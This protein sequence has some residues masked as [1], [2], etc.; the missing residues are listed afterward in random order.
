[1]K[2]KKYVPWIAGCL[3]LIGLILVLT[4][5][6]LL[7]KNVEKEEEQ[8]V[9]LTMMLPQTH[10]KNFFIQLIDQFE[11]EHE[12]IQIELQV[13]PDNQWLDVVK[14]KVLVC[15]TPDII[16]IDRYLLEDIGAE[17]FVEMTEE[18]PWYDRVIPMQRES[19]EV[20]GK[21][22]GLPV[23]SGESFGV[24]YNREIFERYGLEIPTNIEEFEEV[25][26]KLKQNNEIP[27]YVSD[28]DSWTVQVAFNAI[29]PQVIE[30]A[31]WEKLRVGQIS[32][33]EI[34]EFVEIFQRMKGLRE[35]GYTNEN[36]RDATYTG[37]VNVMAHGEAAMYIAGNFFVQDAL[38]L[39][40]ELDLMVFPVPYERDVL[41]WMEG[42]GQLSVFR[43]CRHQKEAELFLNWFSQAEHMDVFTEG[44]GC[45]PVFSDQKQH[46]SESQQFLQEEYV[47]PGRT[48]AAVQDRFPEID[49]S[50]FWTCQQGVYIGT[51]S[52]QEALDMWDIYYE[53]QIAAGAGQGGM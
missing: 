3:G 13:I 29:A 46:L 23:N 25:C 5:L 39:N 24:V 27:V 2:V 8:T 44:W 47:I 53:R 32:W 33:S 43:D 31:V 41:T 9:I 49:W 18:K 4:V 16:R 50:D 51:L 28:K 12:H 21:L 37:A 38:A 1:M 30:Q 45:L 48:V 14:K 6:G 35:K 10:N 34:P 36:Y 22:Y 42:Q 7:E 11:R 15:E 20:N 26:E 17:Y 19:K 40:P 52:P